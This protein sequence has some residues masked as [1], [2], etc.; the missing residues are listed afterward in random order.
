M[1]QLLG[2]RGGPACGSLPS[3][4]FVAGA[5]PPVVRIRSGSR[6]SPGRQVRPAASRP[7]WRG[8]EGRPVSR[9][10]GGVAGGPGGRGVVLPRS[11]PLPSLGKQHCGRHWRCSG[12]GGVAP[13]LLRCV[14][15][16]RPRAW[17]VRRSC[18][19]LRVCPPAATP[20]GAGGGRRGGTRRA[21]LAASPPER[22]GPSLGTGDVSSAPG[23]ME[24][25]RPRG[26]Q[27]G[28]R[29][30]GRG[31]GGPRR[32][33]PPPCPLGWP[34]A[35]VPV[36][37][38]LRRTPPGY[39]RSVGVAGWLWAPGAARSAAGGSVWRR[40][41]G[42]GL[43][44]TVRSP[45][46]PRLASGWA[47]LFAHAWVPRF[48]CRSV[49]G[50]AGVSGRSTGG[51]WRAAALAM[52]VAPPPL[53]AAPPPG[54]R[55]AAV[56]PAGLRSPMDW[57]GGR[58]WGRGLRGGGVLRSPPLFP[59]AAPRRSRGGGLMVP[60]LGGQPPTGGAHSSPVSLY[61]FGA[62]PSS[63]PSLGPLA[64]LAVAAR[65]RLAGG[66]GGSGR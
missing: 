41:G 14:V 9:P 36:T 1:A 4:P 27:A 43:L 15:A 16:C 30:G 47:A 51:A 52:A 32:C 17:P 46:F 35:P 22:H 7:A 61:P 26:P 2:L 42:R 31:E 5:F 60:V 48:R 18:A 20:A 62:G 44:A 29:L 12:H 58:G 57:G 56:S 39:A 54:G 25:R 21:N 6:G 63:R 10:P 34:V 40:G 24:G 53:G 49:A 19:L 59:D 45:A 3:P 64:P 28:G 65:C 13:I 50:N 11:V 38:L 8:G 66:G 33:S 23:G 55:G 37:L